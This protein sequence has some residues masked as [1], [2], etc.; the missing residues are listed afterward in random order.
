M[1]RFRRDI[2]AI[3][4][5]RRQLRMALPETGFALAIQ[6]DPARALREQRRREAESAE[7]HAASAR[8]QLGL[9]GGR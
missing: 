7:A 6:E 5:A 4:A 8:R 1:S 9:F 2:A 3:D